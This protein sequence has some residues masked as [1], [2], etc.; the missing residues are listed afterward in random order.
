MC[1]EILSQQIAKIARCASIICFLADC[2]A[3]A[4]VDAEADDNADADADAAAELSIKAVLE[5]PGKSL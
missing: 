4:G 3:S 1:F 2:D 5:S